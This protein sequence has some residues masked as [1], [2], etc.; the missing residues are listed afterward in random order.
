MK[1]IK[2]LLKVLAVA[3]YTS[4]FWIVLL[5]DWLAPNDMNFGL[6]LLVLSTILIFILAAKYLAIHWDE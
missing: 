5:T 3:G 2:F 6:A 4:L 1:E